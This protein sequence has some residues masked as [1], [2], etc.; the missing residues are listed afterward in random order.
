MTQA[1][2]SDALKAALTKARERLNYI[3]DD[4]R[5]LL[6]EI[7]AALSRP[8][9]PA[10]GAEVREMCAEC[11][12]ENLLWDSIIHN[13]STVQHN[14]LNCNDVQCLFVLGCEECSHTVRTVRA[15]SVAE[16]LNSRA[17]QLPSE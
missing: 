7:D 12:S 13:K 6:I 4:D 10:S 1:K 16:M 3:G 15:N 5:E 2:E 9:Q 14:R 11:G 8:T 17:L